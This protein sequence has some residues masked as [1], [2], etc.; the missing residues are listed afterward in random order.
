MSEDWARICPIPVHLLVQLRN[1]RTRILSHSSLES[2]IGEQ[3][4]Q[5]G[6]QGHLKELIDHHDFSK[7]NEYCLHVM[8]NFLFEKICGGLTSMP[9]VV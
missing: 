4:V 6:N 7:I 9:N 2:S 5:T 1:F 3:V 8:V